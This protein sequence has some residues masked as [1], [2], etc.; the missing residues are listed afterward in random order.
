MFAA[1]G[2]MAQPS[3]KAGE[4]LEAVGAA[5]AADQRFMGAALVAQDG[6][7]LLDR[8]FGSADLEWGLPNTPE[9]KFRIG[10]LTKQFTAALVL[11]LQEEGKLN[12]ADP[13]SRY[14]P[15]AP[16][17][18][19][20][21]TLA[22][23]LN[24]TSGIADFTDLPSFPVWS[25]SPHTPKEI[26][27]LVADKPLAFEPG[28]KFVYSNTNYEILGAVIEAVDGRPYA[29]ALHDR[30]L[31]PLGLTDT[32]L[33]ADDLILAHRASGYAYRGHGLVYDRSES[34]SVPYAAGAMYST[35]HDLLRWEQALFGGKV[36]SAPS[37]ALMTKARLGDY[38]MGLIAQT[39]QGEPIIWH[40]GGI[41]GFH[42]YLAWLPQR[43][44]VVVVL[45]NVVTAPVERIGL[46]LIDAA[47][48][49]QVILP[50]DRKA[51]PIAAADLERFVGTFVFPD[52]PAPTKIEIE[53]GSLVFGQG[54]RPLTYLGQ[55]AGHPVF[56]DASRDYELEFTP[57]AKG[58]MTS[59]ILQAGDV[60]LTGRRDPRAG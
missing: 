18:W 23:L 35:T 28:A 8:G 48:G 36:L 37:L 44:L 33:D 9:V 15:A 32:G 60:T 42:T 45:S 30:I 11:R 40:N 56:W 55:K 10:S 6:R 17:A 22:D 51:Q 49:R 20:K 7:I 53:N 31:G 19:A 13:V 5:Y 14:L 4:R 52:Q 2:A 43:R 1:T 38:A 16:A 54:R 59:V 3:L 34:M 41:E 24:Q 27:A 58:A 21:V 25:A 46:Q 47:S 50:S 29:Q 26:L 57:D 12:V 39:H